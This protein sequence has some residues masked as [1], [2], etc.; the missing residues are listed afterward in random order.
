MSQLV[1][2]FVVAAVLVLLVSLCFQWSTEY[3]AT[4]WR[5][6]QRRERERD[7]ALLLD[8]L[9]HHHGRGRPG[10]EVE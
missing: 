8:C 3:L 10:D 9:N 4:L 5:E 7:S 2:S 1:A 6:H